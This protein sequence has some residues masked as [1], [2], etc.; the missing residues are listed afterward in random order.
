MH[1]ILVNYV[2]CLMLTN[3]F[4]PGKFIITEITGD[5]N[6]YKINTT[7]EVL[8]KSQNKKFYFADNSQFIIII[9]KNCL[10]LGI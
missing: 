8:I 10:Y 6:F 1:K 2:K 3:D 4:L 9:I 7:V 5:N